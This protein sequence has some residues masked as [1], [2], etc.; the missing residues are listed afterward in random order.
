MQQ[1]ILLVLLKSHNF[2][3]VHELSIYIK[4]ELNHLHVKLKS[5][6]NINK[7]TCYYY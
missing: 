2:I 5:A 1:L 3:P 7:K 4:K 6:I